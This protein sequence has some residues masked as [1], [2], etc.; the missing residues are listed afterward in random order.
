MGIPTFIIEEHNE[1]FFIWNYAIKKKIIP[2]LGNTLFHVDEHSDMGAPR[3]NKSINNLKGRTNNVK[4]FTH[5]ELSISGFITPA[6][7]NKIINRVYWIRQNHKKYRIRPIK[8]FVRSYNND[9]K[10]LIKGLVS[11]IGKSK[12]NL[13]S[14]E[15]DIKYFY[16][17]S[18]KIDQ[19]PN[20]KRVILDIDLDY[21]SCIGNPNE[22]EET[23]IEIT[24]SEYD[25]FYCNRYHK[26]NYLNFYKLSAE[27]IN[28]RYFYI[29]NYFNEVHPSITYVKEDEILN[30]INNFVKYLSEKKVKPLLIDICRS[31][32]SGFTPKEQWEFIER[33]LLYK[34]SDSFTLEVYPIN[35]IL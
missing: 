26:T 15:T 33:N 20:N 30:R 34:I 23:Y 7:Y 32:Y 11:T 3:F 19:I 6:I 35:S 14:E 16:Y 18:M 10:K 24:K 4:K 1:A 5:E 9:G 28:D 17:H 2:A 22:I 12:I 8:M 27:K 31:R 21:F 13:I 25:A 29:I